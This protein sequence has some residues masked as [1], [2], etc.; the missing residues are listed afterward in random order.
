[1]HPAFPECP[2]SP[3]GLPLVGEPLARDRVRAAYVILKG[4]FWVIPEMAALH[5]P[6]L[7]RAN[8]FVT[9]ILTPISQ[10]FV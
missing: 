10:I 6:A 8:P 2:A 9:P 1:M 3:L 4:T 7:S 5:R